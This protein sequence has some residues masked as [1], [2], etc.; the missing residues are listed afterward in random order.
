MNDIQDYEAELN[1]I[2]RA[3]AAG[4]TSEVTWA[5]PG[6]GLLLRPYIEGEPLSEAELTGN[7]QL[8]Q[9]GGMLQRLHSNILQM[10]S[11]STT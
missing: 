1:V 3:A 4:L 2:E 9:L 8:D 6:K 11:L 5:D 7:D 10:L